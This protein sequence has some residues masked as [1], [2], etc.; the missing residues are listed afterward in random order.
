MAAP[1]GSTVSSDWG[2]CGGIRVLKAAVVRKSA[3]LG[4]IVRTGRPKCLPGGACC[5]VD[6]AE[7]MQSRG[8]AVP[9]RGRCGLSWALTAEGSH[10][11]TTNFHGPAPSGLP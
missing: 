2:S 6:L 11:W 10:S 7:V 8:R 4:G 5:E 3:G 9:S 1:Y